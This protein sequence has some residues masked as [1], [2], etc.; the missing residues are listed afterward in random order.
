VQILVT[1][2]SGFLGS[3][4]CVHGQREGHRVVGT[5]HG[6]SLS[7]GHCEGVRLDIQD[8]GACQRLCEEWKPDTVIHCARYA[9]GLGR[10]EREREM[11]YRINVLGTRNMA[12]A[13]CEAKARFIYISSDW[14]FDG[15]KTP[16]EKY[17]EGDNPCPLNY[18]GF[19]KWAGEQEVRTA[20]VEW[21]ILRPANIYGIHACLLGDD[22]QQNERYLERTSWAH[23]VAMK[24]RKGETIMLPN[25]LYQTPTLADRFA[26][27]TF[28]L[29][30][31]GLT[32][33]FHV[34]CRNCVSRYRF[35]RA[36]ADALELNGDLICKGS[37]KQ[38]EASW[39]VPSGSGGILPVNTCLDVHKV[40]D[41]L[42]TKMLDLDEGLEQ[43]KGLYKRWEA[44]GGVTG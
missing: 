38:L 19:T 37:L 14:I 13:A 31:R 39:E 6:A 15:R 44:S 5:R 21:L 36:L 28:H 18:Y 17:E 16:G 40:E 26:E 11:A 35:A 32:G 7:L 24:L 43:M 2:A 3:N 23:K 41:A 9:V 42:G 8:Q 10:C 20:G 1:G 25:T 30:E 34:G 4:F 33:V 22:D 29:L 12:Q 27:I